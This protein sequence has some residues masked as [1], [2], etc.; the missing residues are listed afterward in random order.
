MR[1]LLIL[2]VVLTAGVFASHE[3]ST[4]AS[5]AESVD[6]LWISSVDLSGE[7]CTGSLPYH[8]TDQAMDVFADT[9]GSMC[10]STTSCCQIP[11]NMRTWGFADTAH[12][13]LVAFIVSIEPTGGKCDYIEA[14]TVEIGSGKLLGTQRYVHARGSDGEAINIWV[15][16]SPG[17]GAQPQ[18]G[19]T[20]WDG[21]C[22][23]GW[24]GHQ[25]HQGFLSACGTKG[26]LQSSTI[27][28]T[29]HYLTYVNRFDYTEG[30]NC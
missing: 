16:P 5:A 26:G 25:V 6:L 20:V 7:F 14:R 12:A 28:P 29:W 24:T 10:G 9:Q 8:L 1:K 18:L 3:S 4:P 13:S 30:T 23:G 15:A 27:Y 17:F 21:N 2:M 22:T 19:N 11:V